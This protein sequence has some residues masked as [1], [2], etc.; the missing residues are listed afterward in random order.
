VGSS[1]LTFDTFLASMQ[2]ASFPIRLIFSA[3][4]GWLVDGHGLPVNA[5]VTQV[6]VPAREGEPL[7]HARS[8]F[9]GRTT[10][11]LEWLV[12]LG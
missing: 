2:P 1:V 6:S 11:E 12:P 10:L 7:D 5:A 4:A 3:S 8:M 9:A